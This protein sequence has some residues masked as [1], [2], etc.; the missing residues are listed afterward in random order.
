MA[1]DVEGFDLQR[2]DRCDDLIGIVPERRP[3]LGIER[4]AETRRVDC[5]QLVGQYRR[6]PF[7]QRRIARSLGGVDKLVDA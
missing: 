4:P 6:Q 3:V 2:I 5:H 1:E 7:E